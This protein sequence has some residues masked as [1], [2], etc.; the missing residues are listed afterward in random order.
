MNRHRV[1]SPVAPE[2][3]TRNAGEGQGGGEPRMSKVGVPPTP[4][5]CPQGGGES[6]RASGK[7]CG[8]L[9]RAVRVLLLAVAIFAG[10]TVGTVMWA[11]VQLE[12]LSL[13]RAEALS[14]TVLDRNDRLLRAY[15]AQDGRLHREG[16]ILCFCDA[17]L[18]R[19]GNLAR[20][21]RIVLSA[22]FL[23]PDL[24]EVEGAAVRDVLGALGIL[25]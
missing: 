13:A 7:S 20:S 1:P 19:A 18:H 2:A 22:W 16:D 17:F 15:V 4:N 8:L 24:T 12:P 23:H 9:V 5:P 11:W 14:V 3:R 21:N 25:R 10:V 6:H